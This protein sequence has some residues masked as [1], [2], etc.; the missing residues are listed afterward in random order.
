MFGK[1]QHGFCEAK[2]CFRKF[3]KLFKEVNKHVDMDDLANNISLSPSAL[4]KLMIYKKGEIRK[5]KY[6][7]CDNIASAF[8][9]MLMTPLFIF[10]PSLDGR[11]CPSMCL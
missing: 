1:S 2:S 8:T 6:H 10:L 3:L 9:C 11:N 5:K 4:R 7:S